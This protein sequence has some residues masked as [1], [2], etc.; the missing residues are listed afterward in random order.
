VS[1]RRPKVGLMLPLFT[2]DPPRVVAAAREAE[3][4]GFDGVFAFDH[5]FRMGGRPDQPSLDA[6]ATLGAVAGAT[7]RVAVGT[8]VCR[9]GLRPA[10][11]VAK[12][13]AT[14]DLVS[15]GR[16]IL[17]IGSGDDGNRL[18]HETFGFAGVPAPDRRDHLEETV[19]AVGALLG[20]VAWPG[21]AHVEAI[22][23]PIL[24]PAGP[25]PIWVG[26]VSDALVDLAARRAD[27]WN[28]WGLPAARFASKA[29]RLRR[30]AGD[31]A[32]EATWAGI[33][34]V[35]RDRE[36]ASD[37]LESRRRAGRPVDVGGTPGE[38]AASLRALAD[39]GA[40]WAILL[41]AGPAGRREILAEHVLPAL[42]S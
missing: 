34:A 37:L 27:G 38:V 19:R 11:M 28:G 17:G 2:G 9:A 41:A 18:E 4:M 30:A 14:L 39:A 40:T 35:G 22:A 32:V 29:A 26:G 25:V 20:G 31:R 3:A 1:D 12:L 10:G 33:A 36:E 23:G 6:F 15:G 24:P 7:S 5:L 8:L 21:G 16:M 42:A 13:A